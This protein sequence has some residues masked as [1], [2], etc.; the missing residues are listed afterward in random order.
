V[1]EEGLY[2]V[3]KHNLNCMGIDS[4]M[5]YAKPLPIIVSLND[6]TV[7]FDEVAQL[8]LDAG[9]FKSYLWQP[10]GETS[11]YIYS[12]KAQPYLLTVTDS[13]NCSASKHFDVLETCPDFIFVPNAFTPNGDGINDV[14]LPHTRSL[15]Q[16]QMTILNRWG[17]IVFTTT[18]TTKGWDAKDAPADVYVV[19]I[20]YHPK[21]KSPQTISQNITV[22]R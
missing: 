3:Q 16:Y 22:L 14:F 1:F 12:S 18:D 5:V 20:S 7:C 11:R 21:G 9:T 17:Q 2:T 10:T 19:Q 6:T 8:L 15:L 13:N 4:F